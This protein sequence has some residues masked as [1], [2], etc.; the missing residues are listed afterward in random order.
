MKPALFLTLL[1]ASHVALAADD[2]CKNAMTTLEINDCMQKQFEGADKRLNLRYQEL[3]QKLRQNDNGVAADKDK[4]SSLLAQAQRKW[5]TFRDADCDAK[6]Q[7]YIAGTIRNA[8]FLG[9][10]IERTEQ[11][12]KELDPALW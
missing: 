8:V 7:I 4:P 3:L 11:R 10:K 9:C 1:A 12:I 6:Y 5:I 2:S